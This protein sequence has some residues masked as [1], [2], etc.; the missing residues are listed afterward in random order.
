VLLD[1][2]VAGDLG[3]VAAKRSTASLSR[4][5]GERESSTTA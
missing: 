5:S 1:P 3:I 2:Q 4:K